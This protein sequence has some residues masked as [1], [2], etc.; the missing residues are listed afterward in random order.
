MDHVRLENNVDKQNKLEYNDKRHGNDRM[1]YGYKPNE[2][3]TRSREDFD[4]LNVAMDQVNA[5]VIKFKRNI[6]TQHDTTCN[7]NDAMHM[8]L[9]K[10]MNF[11]N[12]T[13]RDDEFNYTEAMKYTTMDHNNN[14]GNNFLF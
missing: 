11:Y 10:V 3:T 9:A 13:L 1:L 14:V 2:P 7:Y 5:Q 12:R 8:E 4:I 6:V